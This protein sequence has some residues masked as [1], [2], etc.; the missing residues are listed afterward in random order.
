MNA[1]KTYKR[2]IKAGRKSLR[3]ERKDAWHV[4]NTDRQSCG[5]T[6]K[7]QWQGDKTG[8][9]ADGTL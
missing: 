5:V 1:W 2:E 8:S 9:S 3:I 7:S 4:Y 6:A